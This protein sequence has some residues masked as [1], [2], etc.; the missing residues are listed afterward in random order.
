MIIK[1]KSFK[2]VH[3]GECKW[4]IVDS[5]LCELFEKCS[6]D[7]TLYADELETALTDERSV[8][9]KRANKNRFRIYQKCVWMIYGHVVKDT[10]HGIDGYVMELVGITFLIN[11]KGI[12]TRT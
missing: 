12:Q 9:H 5:K 2:I 3:E 11:G 6:F 10:R 8:D 7:C 4:Q 1:I